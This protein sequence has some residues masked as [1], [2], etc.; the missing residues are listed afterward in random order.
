MKLKF[1]VVIATYNGEK[2]ILEQLNSILT[3]SK[4][5]GEIV[6]TDD[7]STDSTKDIVHSFIKNNKRDITIKFV[8]HS[9]TKSIQDN[10]IYGCSFFENVDYIFFCDQDDVWLENKVELFYEQI[11]KFN[12]PSFVFSDAKVVDSNLNVINK[13]L[14]NTLSDNLYTELCDTD[15]SIIFLQNKTNTRAVLLWNIATGMNTCVKFELIKKYNKITKNILHDYF[16]FMISYFNNSVLFIPKQSALYRQHNFNC[17][18]VNK[19]KKLTQILKNKNKN[20]ENLK[21]RLAD[22]KCIYSEILNYLT[23]DSKSF[24]I[25]FINFYENRIKFL[26]TNNF[27][28]ILF[29]LQKYKLFTNKWIKQIVK[30]LLYCLWR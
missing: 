2:Y 3:Q 15:K 1:G 26:T 18:G 5:V 16:Y 4:Q 13:S 10:F 19:K 21:S 11:I 12:N 14:V 27:F 23:D 25:S 17:V 8:E 30:D 9:N 24:F 22:Y 20:I 7:G 28:F 29:M 6:I